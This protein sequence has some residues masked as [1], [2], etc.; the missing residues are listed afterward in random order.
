MSFTVKG[1]KRTVTEKEQKTMTFT[2]ALEYIHSLGQGHGLQ[3]RDRIRI[4]LFLLGDPHKGQNYIHI[5]GTNGKGSVTTYLASILR[6][7]GHRVGSFISPYLDSFTERI[8]I[9]GQPI[10]QNELI[11]LTE[12]VKIQVDQM[13][14]QGEKVTQFEFL[15]ALA[16]LWF[17]QQECDIAVV[18]TGIGGLWD[19]TNVLPR[20][21]AAVITAIGQDH[22]ELL[23]DSLGEIATQKC[24]IFAHKGP[25]PVITS[26]GQPREAWDTINWYASKAGSILSS[27]NLEALQV[28]EQGLEG[29][30]IIWQGLELTIPMAGEFQIAN[31]LTAVQTAQR[32]AESGVVLSSQAIIEGIANAYLPGR[33]EVLQQNPLVLVDCAHNPDGARALQR[34]LK[35][36]GIQKATV[37]VGILRD[38]DCW[39][40]LEEVLPYAYRAVTVTPD[41][42]RAMPASQLAELAGRYCSAQPAQDLSGALQLALTSPGDGVVIFGSV[43]LAAQARTFF[44]RQKF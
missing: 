19:A 29:S 12:E 30:R 6:A 7:G 37:V 22:R 39:G 2:G 43:F 28:V 15:T 36:L 20:P 35:V 4:L 11:R 18:E 3:C 13:A 8:Q 5:A 21:L 27:P 38:K 25:C 33:M 14:V 31:A 40:V 41:S 17:R 9:G 24:G 34:S 26:P 32:L 42:S 16:L 23:G 10:S 44:L 1:A